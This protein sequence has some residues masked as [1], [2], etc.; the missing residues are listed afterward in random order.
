MLDAENLEYIS[1]VGLRVMKQQA[2]PN[3]LKSKKHT[4]ESIGAL[5]YL[6]QVLT[7]DEMKKLTELYQSIPDRDTFVHGDCHPGNVMV[8]DGEMM[9]IDLGT[10]GTGH[11]IF[12]IVSMHSLFVERADNA[13]AIAASPVL[14]A[15]TSD[16]IK[17]IWNV[18]IHTYLDTSDEEFVAEA[19]KQIAALSLARRL[20]MIVAIPSGSTLRH[21]AGTVLTL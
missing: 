19:Q 16:E 15:F 10:A 5:Q 9:F 17:R 3:F 13:E 12:D 18:F 11:P 6:S 8:R 21:E 2:L 4:A 14:R 7:D 1:S 20:F